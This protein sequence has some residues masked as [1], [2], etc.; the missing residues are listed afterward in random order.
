MSF[1]SAEFIP[2]ENL[3]LNEPPIGE[4]EFGSVYKGIYQTREGFE[5]SYIMF[6]ST[7]WNNVFICLTL[8]KVYYYL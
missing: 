3:I 8:Q 6:V 5:V 2:N 1:L 7:E 4:G